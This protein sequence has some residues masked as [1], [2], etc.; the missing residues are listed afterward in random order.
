MYCAVHVREFFNCSQKIHIENVVWQ[1]KELEK[2]PRLMY[3]QVIRKEC[4]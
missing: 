1:E 4:L 3:N 2:H